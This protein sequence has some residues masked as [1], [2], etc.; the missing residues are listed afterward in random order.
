[1]QEVRTSLRGAVKY[2]LLREP[3]AI[4]VK[5]GRIGPFSLPDILSRERSRVST[6]RML[7]EGGQGVAIIE[8]SF[9]QRWE[10][11]K[12][13]DAQLE[14]ERDRRLDYYRSSGR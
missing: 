4:S 12:K 7:T 2:Q 3:I 6:T 1:M 9:L 13:L 14:T 8:G 11:A 10:I 5:T